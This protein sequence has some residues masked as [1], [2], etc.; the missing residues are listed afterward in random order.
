MNI[1]VRTFLIFVFLALV[2]TTVEKDG[3]RSRCKTSETC[4]VLSVYLYFVRDEGISGWMKIWRKLEQTEG[5]RE[6]REKKK[7]E[8]R[9]W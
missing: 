9:R 4:F 3:K 7:K 6:Q 2:S 5:G 1:T 8:E